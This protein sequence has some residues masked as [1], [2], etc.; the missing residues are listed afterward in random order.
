MD[1]T[2]LAA[3]G[4][5]ELRTL[6]TDALE[7]EADLSYLRRLLQGRVDILR[8]ELDRRTL[9]RQP[10]PA[11]ETLLHRLPQILADAPSHVRQSA[12][13]VTLGTPRGE[14]Y[15][16]QADALMGDVQLADLAAHACAELLAALDR[17]TAREREISGRRS[18]LQRTADW[19]SAEITRRY[20]EGEARVED[21]LVD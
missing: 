7:Q 11:A 18:E 19:C 15:Q 3:L 14:Q 2:Q 17:L 20:R 10:A 21:L 6:R 8:A 12:R 13:H 9:D 16:E 4:L 5:A 1:T